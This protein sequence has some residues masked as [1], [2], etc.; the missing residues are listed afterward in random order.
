V[1]L[2]GELIQGVLKVV[3]THLTEVMDGELTQGVLTV[4]FTH[5]TEVRKKIIRLFGDTA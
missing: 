1:F 4:V 5:P 3:F 2:G